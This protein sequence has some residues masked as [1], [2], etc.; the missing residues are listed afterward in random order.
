MSD[1]NN[2]S[3][4][5]PELAAVAGSDLVNGLRHMADDHPCCAATIA[6]AIA[7]IERLRARLSATRKQLRAANKGAERN[8]IVAQLLA[9]RAALRPNVADQPTARTE[10]RIHG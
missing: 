4:P 8:A 2:Q 3:A 1:S 9:S 5:E 6:Q 10:P 7:E